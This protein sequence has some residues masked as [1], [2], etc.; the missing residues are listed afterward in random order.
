MGNHILSKR[1][2]GAHLMFSFNTGLSPIMKDSIW[3][4]IKN[5]LSA[6]PETVQLSKDKWFV[7]NST[8]VWS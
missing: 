2:N 5:I 7:H 6:C 4:P 3:V 8:G 1:Y